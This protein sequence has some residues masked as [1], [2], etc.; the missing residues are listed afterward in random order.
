MG[1]KYKLLLHYE[2]YNTVTCLFLGHESLSLFL[3]LFLEPFFGLELAS[4]GTDDNH[5]R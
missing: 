4:P 2:L 3:C 5:E 1:S